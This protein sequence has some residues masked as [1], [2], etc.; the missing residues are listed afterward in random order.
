MHARCRPASNATFQI[1]FSSLF[2]QWHPPELQL[3]SRPHDVVQQPT[4]SSRAADP[5]LQYY[6]YSNSAP[7]QNT[8][9]THSINEEGHNIHHSFVAAAVLYWSLRNT[10][11][12]IPD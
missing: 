12:V 11:P 10:A 7:P 8:Q 5:T 1:L 3:V 6:R 9:Y 2:R 4:A